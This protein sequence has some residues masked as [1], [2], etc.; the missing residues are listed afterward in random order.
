MC[1][2]ALRSPFQATTTRFCSWT[3]RGF[4]KI[5]YMTLNNAVLIPVPRE[6]TSTVMR[7]NLGCRTRIRMAC[8]N[9]RANLDT[10]I[11][12][13]PLAGRN[14]GLM[15]RGSQSL[16]EQRF[17]LRENCAQIEKQAVFFYARNHG[18]P[19]RRAAQA[20][21]QLRRRVARAGDANH[22]ARQ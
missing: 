17:L 11:P 5:P 1:A 10:I 9:S 19:C 22:F 2:A 4:S 14:T 6:S 16:D 15:E 13:M 3:G 20:L 12:I 7:R 21:L 18:N 8:K